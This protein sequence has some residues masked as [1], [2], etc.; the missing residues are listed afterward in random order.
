MKDKKQDAVERMCNIQRQFG[1][2]VIFRVGIM[3]NGKTIDII[4]AENTFSGKKGKKEPEQELEMK[5]PDV[6]DYI[7]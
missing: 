5:L 1:N 2:A 7:G 3:D 4:S 6:P